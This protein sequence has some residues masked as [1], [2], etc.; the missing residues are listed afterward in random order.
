MAT[1]VE[2]VGTLLRELVTAQQDTDR[3]FQWTD[4]NDAGFVPAIW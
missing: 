2:E 4:R 3:K 1:R